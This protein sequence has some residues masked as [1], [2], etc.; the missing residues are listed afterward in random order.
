MPCV[1]EHLSP[2][3]SVPLRVWLAGA[4]RR[5]GSVTVSEARPVQCRSSRIE[6]TDSGSVAGV[7]V[8][9]CSSRGIARTCAD[10]IAPSQSVSGYDDAVLTEYA[11]CRHDRIPLIAMS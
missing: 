4:R 11:C 2:L 9:I 1:F 3:P 5:H 8:I 10:G 6:V 7:G